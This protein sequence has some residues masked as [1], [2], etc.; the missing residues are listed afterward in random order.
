MQNRFD[1][2]ITPNCIDRIPLK[3][4][5]GFSQL[6]ADEWKNRTHVY[7]IYALNILP[8]EKH[9]QCWSL[10]VHSLKVFCKKA[11]TVAKCL[12]ANEVF[13]RFCQDFY[14]LYGKDDLVINTH[15]LCQI[16]IF[17]LLV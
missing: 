7:S 8:P 9:L 13:I 2:L 12:H 11:I 1:H 3:L 4:S 6:K 5:S 17:Y 15:L 16:F 14:H 10:F